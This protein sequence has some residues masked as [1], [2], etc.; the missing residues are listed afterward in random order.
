MPRRKL[1]NRNV[2]KIFK[3]GKAYC[4]TLPIE[5]IRELGWKEKQKVVFKKRGKGLKIDDW[6]K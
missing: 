6:T 5:M 3:S 1:E 4:V 2:R